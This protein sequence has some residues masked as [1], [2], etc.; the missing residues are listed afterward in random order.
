MKI[1]K[2]QFADNMINASDSNFIK[3]LDMFYDWKVKNNQ[4]MKQLSTA[5]DSL[6]QSIKSISTL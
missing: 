2:I 4:E 5:V 1:E 6:H 3:F